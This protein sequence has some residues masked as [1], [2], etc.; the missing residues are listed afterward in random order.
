[1]EKH[2]EFPVARRVGTVIGIGLT[3]LIFAL[4]IGPLV[5]HHF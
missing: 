3:V 2:E 1:M 5:Y 4:A